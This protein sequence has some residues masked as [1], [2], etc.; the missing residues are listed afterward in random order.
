MWQMRR[1]RAVLLVLLSLL[2]TMVCWFMWEKPSQQTRVAKGMDSF[3]LPAGIS[4]GIPPGNTRWA[5]LDPG[6]ADLEAYW[7][8]W[9]TLVA[10]TNESL[11]QVKKKP[12]PVVPQQ[13]EVLRYALS[14]IITYSD[15]YDLPPIDFRYE[16]QSAWVLIEPASPQK[17]RI[18]GDTYTVGAILCTFGESPLQRLYVYDA[19]TDQWAVAEVRSAPDRWHD[20]LRTYHKRLPKGEAG[21]GPGWRT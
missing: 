6:I 14:G 8:D 15:K 20:W 9:P 12:R 1:H 5:A 11:A 10:L 7:W 3:R 16:P 19:F 2:G 17:I 13:D 4:I 21:A 18:R